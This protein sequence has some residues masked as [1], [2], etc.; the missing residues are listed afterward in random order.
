MSYPHLASLLAV[1]ACIAFS[2]PLQAQTMYRCGSA[3]QD[4][5]CEN[6]QQ[7]KIIGVNR[8]P[9][10]ADKPALDLSCT[11]RGEEAKKIIWSREGGASAEKLMAE[12]NSS[13]RRKLIADVYAI[14][15]NSSEV[16]AAIENDC[17]AEKTRMRHGGFMPEDEAPAPS[18]VTSSAAE[19]KFSASAETEKRVDQAAAADA[20]AT[21]KRAQCDY[22][23]SQLSNNRSNQRAG[24]A[25]STMNSLNQ[26]RSDIE[27]ELKSAQCDGGPGSMQMR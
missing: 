5:P 10:T 23:K 13:E 27:A 1:S 6:G 4:R 26:Q 12:T 15:A 17:M 16:R 20:A 9:D 22:L 24:G 8:A 14:R 25:S 3:Y 11:R 21:R 19:R 2:A 18:R 7:G